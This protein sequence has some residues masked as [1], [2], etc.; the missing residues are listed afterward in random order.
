M[1]NVGNPNNV[2]E[3]KLDYIF[4]DFSDIC[5]WKIQ[6]E[7]LIAQLY[8]ISIIEELLRPLLYF[9]NCL[10]TILTNPNNELAQFWK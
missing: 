6:L 8:L 9:D 4:R 3:V 10:T 2:K 5:N 1:Q 7:E